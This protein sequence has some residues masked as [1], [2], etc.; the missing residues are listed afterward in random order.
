MGV[1]VVLV[2][3]LSGCGED[4]ASTGD[5]SPGGGSAAAPPPGGPARIE[6]VNFKY[7]PEALSV[8]AG[9]EITVVNADKAP[10]TITA[11]DDSFDSGNLTQNQQ[12]SLTLD[13]AGT[14]DYICDLHQYMK[15][16]IEVSPAG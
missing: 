8:R 15:G 2:A 9:Q 3:A 5:D 13:K 11:N 7:V 10:H 1:C 4:A 6:I 12:Y 14:Y 16:T